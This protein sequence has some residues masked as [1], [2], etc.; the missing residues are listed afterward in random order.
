[1]KI[2]T[3]MRFGLYLSICLSLGLFSCKKSTYRK[4]DNGVV[5][6]LQKSNTNEAKTICL[7]VI[8]DDIIRVMASPLDTFSTRKSLIIVPQK[9][10]NVPFE[11]TEKDNIL[12]LAT[13]KIKAELNEK[14]GHVGFYKLD[15]SPL[16]VE[17]ASESRDFTPIEADGT[18]GYSFQQVFNSPEDEAF[19]GLGQHQ[20][21]EWN[22]KGKNEELYQYNTKVSI[23]FIVSNKNY[24]LLWDNYSLTRFG[25]PKEYNNI[26]T[27]F[28]LFD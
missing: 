19:Y 25:N 2:K 5:I 23:P 10:K 1:M 15:G 20:S 11:I 27:S 6:T 16:L 3:R 14:T 28:K 13:Q 8:S 9:K 22:Y 17:D 18:R 24:G 26:S 7:K 12:E 21:N 4:I